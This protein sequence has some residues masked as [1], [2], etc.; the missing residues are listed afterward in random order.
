[1][2][3]I[4]QTRRGG[5]GSHSN[6]AFAN[7]GYTNA[8]SD[9]G[10]SQAFSLHP[11]TNTWKNKPFQDDHID[12]QDFAFS[13]F[14][15]PIPYTNSGYTNAFSDTGYSNAFSDSPFSDTFSQKL[16]QNDHANTAH[17]DVSSPGGGGGIDMRVGPR[18]ETRIKFK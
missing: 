1:M 13:D 5:T 15:G 3:R 11:H 16:F 9:I 4:Q 14:Y 17:I 7:T 12:H 18:P 2:P 8:F 6:T 10:H